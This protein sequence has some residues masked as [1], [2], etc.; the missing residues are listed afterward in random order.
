MNK[1][2]DDVIELCNEYKELFGN[3]YIGFLEEYKTKIEQI[4]SKYEKD[5][6]YDQKAIKESLLHEMVNSIAALSIR[7]LIVEIHRMKEAGK[8]EG[9]DE[10][11]RYDYFN[12]QLKSQKYL[13]EVFCMYPVLKELIKGTIDGTLQLLEECLLHLTKDIEQ[14]RSEFHGSY[15]KIEN[16]KIS[17]GDTHNGGKKVIII[18]FELSKL[19][20]KPHGMS[21]EN[22]FNNMLDLLNEEKQLDC[23]LLGVKCIDY[24]NYGW[25]E[26]ITE[27]SCSNKKMV[28]DYFYRIGCFLS[29]FYALNCDDM[30]YENIIAGGEHPFF[31]DLETLVRNQNFHKQ[32]NLSLLELV[33]KEVNES[34]LGTMLL[35]CNMIFSLF[36]C[37]IGGISGS[38]SESSK[39][40]MKFM[41]EYQGTDRIH[42]VKKEC[43]IADANNIVKYQGQSVE[44]FY[45]LENV[46]KGFLECYKL[47]L[48]KKKK[49]LT[50]I[51]QCDANVRQVL[52]GTSVYARFLEAASFP[53]YLS[54]QE[55][56][57]ELFS[58][59]YAGMQVDSELERKKTRHEIAALMRNDIPYF[60]QMFQSTD[61]ICNQ[62]DIITGFYGKN[63]Y[64]QIVHRM[65]Q[66]NEENLEKQLYYI[67]LSFSTLKLNEQKVNFGRKKT[68]V[69]YFHET[70]EFLDC[71]K[72]LGDKITKYTVWSQD[73]STCTWLSATQT[74]QEYKITCIND[75]LY[76]GGGVI[77]FLAFLGYISKNDRYSELARKG[78]AG[79]EELGYLK[80]I[81]NMSLFTGIGSMIYL[82]Y[83]FYILY[84]SRNYK[85]KLMQ[86]I[87]R[88]V[89]VMDEE[90]IEDD[91]ISGVSGTIIVLCEIHSELKDNKIAECIQKMGEVLYAHLSWED[92]SHLT[93]FSHG[94]SGY[95]VALTWLGELTK[96][97]KYTSLAEHLLEIENRYFDEARKNWKDLRE[98]GSFSSYW[99]HGSG[100]IA[101]ARTLLLNLQK[102]NKY[103]KEVKAGVLD[104]K[105]NGFVRDE[106]YNHS[107][108]HGSFGN[109]DILL[110]IAEETE[111][112][113]LETF[114]KNKALDELKYIREVGFLAG[115]KNIIDNNSFMLG[116]S[117]IGY[118]LL[119]LHDRRVPSILSLEVI[120]NQC[121]R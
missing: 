35:P 40:W 31:I 98:E 9:E 55:K 47:I 50:L 95:A 108:C 68:V 57:L 120:K 48:A 18:E 4:I 82:Y 7:T 109:I 44:L 119:R 97:T 85:E 25:Q 10:V 19:V 61:L 34:V 20:Y 90:K 29:I 114:A 78:I 121:E 17:S 116:L 54:G 77:L 70:Y 3:F 11:T 110:K 99:C 53:M 6:V 102:K 84:D 94:Y 41:V 104:L 75:K 15:H 16:I 12:N 36:D 107:L 100:G 33:A 32:E 58:K 56:R 69:P 96:D 81:G 67:R 111:D 101:L 8:L 49:F 27:K 74:D 115:T 43:N 60:S 92:E 39:K 63:L 38:S 105:R 112:N 13:E 64:E 93:G 72:E 73:H 42:L 88:V 52:R 118:E 1:L 106:K 87:D 23:R 5:F 66:M 71:A 76:E 65:E 83:T 59:M 28:E 62:T 21:P 80:E 37:D 45:F 26:F 79:I 89:E 113:E 117:G 14:I 46:E 2:A 30:H 103:R 24:R 91:I 22:M 86:L 51:R